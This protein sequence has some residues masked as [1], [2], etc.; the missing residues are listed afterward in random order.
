[1]PTPGPSPG[2]IIVLVLVVMSVVGL[3]TIAAFAYT[4][5][6]VDASGITLRAMVLLRI[7]LR[8][9]WK[10]ITRIQ[11]V[12]WGG[13]IGALKL[14]GR[15]LIQRHLTLMRNQGLRVRFTPRDMAASETMV[16]RFLQGSSEWGRTPIGWER[17]HPPGA[18]PTTA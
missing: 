3:A 14:D 15:Y 10:V 16:G 6:Q 11:T 13:G 9:P 5:W 8:I 12:G 17:R 2:A 18:K 7:P 1:M 4:R